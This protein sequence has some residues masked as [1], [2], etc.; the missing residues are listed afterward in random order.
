MSG[1]PSATGGGNV[2]IGTTAPQMSLD[3]RGSWGA[4]ATS[5]TAATGALRV[6]TNAYGNSLDFGGYATSPYALWLQGTERSNLA[7]VYPIALQPNGGY[8]G[9]GFTS[10]AAK[11][12]VDG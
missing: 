3:T 5:G 8:V 9:I 10:P 1:R 2:G 12:G 11:L 4:P 6:A 7:T